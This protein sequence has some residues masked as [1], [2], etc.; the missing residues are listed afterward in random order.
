MNNHTLKGKV[1]VIG[2][3]AKNLGGLLSREFAKSGAKIVVRTTT[4]MPP[5]RMPT[6][7]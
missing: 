1:A 6:T 3:G 7:Q 5:S 2:A 4:A